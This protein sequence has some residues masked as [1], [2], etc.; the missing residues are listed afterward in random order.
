MKPLRTADELRERVIELG[1]LPF[2]RNKIPGFSVQEMADPRLWFT[3]EPGPWDWKGPVVRSGDVAYGKLFRGRA[4]YVSREWYP[5]L[6]RWRRESHPV[7]GLQDTGISPSLVLRAIDENGGMVSKELKKLFDAVK[8]RRGANDLVDL[9]GLAEMEYKIN[10]GSLERAL[11]I[12]MMGCHLVIS[13][14]EYAR[15]RAG[16]AY[17]WGLARYDTPE[18]IFGDNFMEPVTDINPIEAREKI[19]THLQHVCPQATRKNLEELVR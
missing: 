19:V 1:F 14:I 7:G 9:T 18:H 6:A 8:R 2:F 4:M 11:D 5:M 17:G 16:V 15:T 3:D 10:R 13:D 12:L